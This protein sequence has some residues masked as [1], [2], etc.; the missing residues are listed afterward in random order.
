MRSFLYEGN[1]YMTFIMEYGNMIIY[2]VLTAILGYVGIEIKKMVS[3]WLT[4]LEKKDVVKTCVM[5][6][7]RLYRKK[8]PKEKYAI[9]LKNIEDML[10]DRN[11]STSKFEIRMLIAEVCESI[12]CGDIQD[13]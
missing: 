3:R 9:A 10:T 12:D 13:E 8:Q 11:I 7:N 4:M 1:D 2:T 5:A 6:V